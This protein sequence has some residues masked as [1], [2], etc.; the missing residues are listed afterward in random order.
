MASRI[1][2]AVKGVRFASHAPANAANPWLAER[3]AVKEHAGRKC[4]VFET[5]HAGATVRTGA[6]LAMDPIGL[7]STRRV[8][9][10]ALWDLWKP[11]GP[12]SDMAFR[13]WTSES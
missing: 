4:Y 3:I 9:I 13:L 8:T 12:I 2:A 11:N 5:I 7:I 1:A 6:A 10:H